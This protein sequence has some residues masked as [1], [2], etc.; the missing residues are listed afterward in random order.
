MRRVFFFL[1][2]VLAG[3]LPGCA[4]APHP[5][6]LTIELYDS[7]AAVQPPP[8]PQPDLPAPAPPAIAV[9]I[10]EPVAQAA[11]SA[12]I[13]PARG[14]PVPVDTGFMTPARPRT[15][16]AF[17]LA[18]PVPPAAPAVA[19]AAAVAAAPAAPRSAV[20]PAPKASTAQPPKSPTPQASSAGAASIPTLPGATNPVTTA[21][22]ASSGASGSYGR[23]RE[24][25]ARQGDELQIGLDGTGFLFLGFPDS[26]Q[27][28]EGMSFKS[29]ETRSN[30]TWFTFKALKLGTFDL[31]FLQQDNSTGK[32]AK[33]TVRVRVVSDQDFNAAVGQQP[34]LD[35]SGS[36]SVETGDPAFAERLKSLGS[37][38]AAITEL[39]KG[40]KDGNPALNDQIAS[41]YM[42][43]G[44]YDAAGKYYGKNLATQ[45]A[46]TQ[47][48]VLGMVRI[49]VAQKDQAGLMATLKQF[50]AINDPAIEEPLIQAARLEKS[51]LETGVGLELAGEYVKRFPTGSWSDEAQ[52]LMAQF[53]EADSQFRDIARARTLYRDILATWPESLFA[54]TAR[55]RLLYIESH[56]FQVR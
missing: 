33:E 51:L 20:A 7:H 4:T 42:R 13:P 14:A 1:I 36:G 23:L 34:G 10:A 46:F 6:V 16:S 50:L 47:G 56:F 26:V 28:G 5:M 40:Y 8:G 44:S 54:D 15:A 37:Y 27:Q 48:A 17:T 53:L 39:L 45:N 24:I 12:P 11:P 41:L 3:L 21:G 18:A 29:K 32:S 55:Q 35:S 22:G 38:E 30:K 31:D 19:P 49:A 2:A 25:F 43:L 52:F 9:V